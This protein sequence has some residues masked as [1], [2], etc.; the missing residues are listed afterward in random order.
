MNASDENQ[1]LRRL[2][3]AKISNMNEFLSQSVPMRADRLFNL[4]GEY[5]GQIRDGKESEKTSE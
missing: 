5:K 1:A 4:E 3:R 2:E